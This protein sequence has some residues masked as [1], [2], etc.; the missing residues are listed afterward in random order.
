M[1]AERF[2]VLAERLARQGKPEALRL[3]VRMAA[4]PLLAEGMARWTTGNSSPTSRLLEDAIPEAVR[5]A[6]SMSEVKVAFADQR[7]VVDLGRDT[8]ISFPWNEHRLEKVL[9]WLAT[10]TW[11][12][13][14][15]NHDV[16]RYRPLGVAVFFNGLHSGAV[17]ILKGEGQVLAHEVDLSPL[18]EGGFRVEWRNPQRGFLK[19]ASETV[20]Y[21]V[22]GKTAE[23]LPEGPGLLLAIGEVL[24]RHGIEL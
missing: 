1:N 7:K 16:Y 11:R 13:D 22:F 24:H 12:Y 19:R 2:V 15:T 8:V 9:E 5:R 3:L 4:L 10:E 21:A 17:G 18:Y 14:S 23:P 20:P 6:L